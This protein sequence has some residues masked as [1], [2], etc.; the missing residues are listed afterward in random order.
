[1]VIG[2]SRCAHD[3]SLPVLFTVVPEHCEVLVHR[4]CVRGSGDAQRSA[5]SSPPDRCCQAPIVGMQPRTPPWVRARGVNGDGMVTVP[6]GHRHH[7][8]QFD[9]Q[10]SFPAADA[11]S[12][13]SRCVA[14][15]PN[16]RAGSHISLRHRR[17]V[18]NRPPYGCR[19]APAGAP[20]GVSA[21]PVDVA[22]DV[23]PP[24]GQS[25][26]QPGVLPLLADGQ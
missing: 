9:G 10:P 6:R 13:R 14:Q 26:R 25:R 15:Q 16:S 12:H 5:E 22:S 18:P 7:P 4:G 2:T 23:D 17:G 11:G 19:R 8:E 24:A 21:R 1:M 3:S 20:G